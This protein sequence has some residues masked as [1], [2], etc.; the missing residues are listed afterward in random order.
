MSGGFS[1]FLVVEIV[2]RR[3]PLGACGRIV[4]LVVEFA[5]DAVAFL[6]AFVDRLEPFGLTK[7]VRMVFVAESLVR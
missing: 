5:V 2:E 4:F 3:F 6:A 7:V 1:V